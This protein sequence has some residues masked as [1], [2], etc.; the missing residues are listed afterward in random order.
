MSMLK[1]PNL[2]SPPPSQF[3]ILNDK[4]LSINSE[5]KQEISNE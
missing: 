5:I 2:I 1:L 3:L 4:S